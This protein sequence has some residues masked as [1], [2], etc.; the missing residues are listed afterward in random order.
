MSLIRTSLLNSIAVIV[1]MLTLLGLNKILAVYVGPSGYAAIGQFQNAAQMITTFASGAINTGVIKYTAEFHDDEVRQRMV[2]RTAGTIAV[3]GSLSTSLI[4]AIL[5]KQLS[6]WF[7]KSIEFSGV[8][9][10]FA[11]TLFFFS[12][13]TLLLAILNGKKEIKRYVTANIIGSIFSLTITGLMVINF[14]LYGALVGLAV[15]QSLSFFATFFLC[16]NAKWFRFR[17]FVGG[18]DR[19]AVLQ[20]CKY[21]AMALTSAACVPVSHLLIRNHLGET[22]GWRAAGF[23]EGIWRLSSAY[24]ML[25]TTTLSV[26][27]LPRLSELKESSELTKEI[28]QGYKIILPLASFCGLIIYIF[29]DLIIQLLFTSEF[30]SM[31]GLFAWQMIGDTLKI[32][33]WILAYLMLSKAMTKLFI[34]T[35]IIF[36]MSF[37]LLTYVLTRY[38]NIQGVV[39]AYAV[40]YLL[41]WATMAFFI[42]NSLKRI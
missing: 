22:L 32:G 30:M 27:Y 24:L 40:N 3:I 21:T 12:F 19:Q 20:L 37:V 25:V 28:I 41:Y 13:N 17:Y 9:L 26:Y 10:W 11:G 23:W 6:E 18:V 5:N 34:T 7:L 38:L 15:H 39:V 1:K 14:G 35:E 16:Y 4:I 42:R 33:S 8:F 31:R 29:R 36:S 2:W